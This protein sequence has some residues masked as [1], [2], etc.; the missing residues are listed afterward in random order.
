MFWAVLVG[1]L[2]LGAGT[3]RAQ[4][5][6]E[7][8]PEAPAAVEATPPPTP[9]TPPIIDPQVTPASGACC[10]GPLLH[11][12]GS[13]GCANGN[14]SGYGGCYPGRNCIG[15][16]SDTCIGRLFCGFYNEI[17]CPDPCYEPA[18]IPA[19]NAAFFQ[20]SPRPVTQT[21]VRWDAGFNLAFP[22]TAEYFW[23][24]MGQGNKGPQGLTSSLKYNE[25]SLYQEVAAK[26]ASMYISVP[27]RSFDAADGNPGSAGMGDLTIGAKTVLLD[28]DLLLISTQFST[29]VPVGNPTTGLGTGHVSLEPAL[30]AALK[31]TPTTYLQTE[32][33]DWIPL[34][35]TPGFAGSVFH[36][37]VSLN[38]NL[39]HQGDCINVVGTVEL[40]GYSF[41]G[42]FTDPSTGNVVG[43]MGSNYLNAGPGIRLQFCDRCDMGIGMVFGFGSSHGPAQLYRT[44]LR[45]RF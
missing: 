42:Q 26:G 44:E 8:P 29:Y 31:L 35:G 12:G 2:L 15:C 21:R 1:S 14:C 16:N 22:D 32:F 19:A 23:A 9:K 34:G 11:G 38:Q 3:L 39:L 20:D 43:L 24:R 7:P 13:S 40:N 45:L 37:H 6:P 17:C 27:Y 25:L 5:A 30:L 18:W 33:A 36:Y 10:S 41:R 4:P 28:R